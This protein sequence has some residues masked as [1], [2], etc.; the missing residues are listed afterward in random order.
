MNW[1]T[2]VGPKD[3]VSALLGL[4]R[5]GA[6]GIVAFVIGSFML[7]IIISAAYELIVSSFGNDTGSLV[8]L[9][10]VAVLVFVFMVMLAVGIFRLIASR[11]KRPAPGPVQTMPVHRALIA[12]VSEG[13]GT[14]HETAVD[15]HLKPQSA[16]D[17]TLSHLILLHSEASHER[18]WTYRQTLLNRADGPR[19]IHPALLENLYDLRECYHATQQAIADLLNTTVEPPLTLDDIVVEA[20]G[21][22]AI[23]SA[24][25]TLVALDRSVALEYI[26]PTLDPVTRRP[27]YKVVKLHKVDIGWVPGWTRPELDAFIARDSA[28]TPDGPELKVET[29]EQG[30]A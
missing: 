29:V 5:V 27:T 25:A 3:I 10:I 13:F 21:G 19:D 11:G 28:T 22:T 6:L 20:T 14:S 7:G 12:F 24:A 8:R 16:D 17:S 2:Q 9:I 1:R 18:A 26:E 23:Y 15:H 4:G 30:P